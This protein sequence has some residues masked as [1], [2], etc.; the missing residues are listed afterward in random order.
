MAGRL[1]KYTHLQPS[2]SLP[3]LDSFP[4]LCGNPGLCPLLRNLFFG[5]TAASSI[6]QRQVRMSEE[7]LDKTVFPALQVQSHT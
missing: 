4:N 6:L 3:F 1:E 5:A 7:P 2:V